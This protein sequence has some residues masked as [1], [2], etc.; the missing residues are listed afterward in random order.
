MSVAGVLELFELRKQFDTVLALDGVS[1]SFSGGQ[2]VALVGP[3]GAGKSTLVKCLAGI[4]KADK[5]SVT[6]D[7]RGYK[8]RGPADAKSRGVLLVQQELDIF[9]ELTVFENWHLLTEDSAL[10]RTVLAERTY[11]RAIDLPAATLE[12]ID[13]QLLLLDAAVAA[14]P[15]VLLLDE[16]TS[17][18]DD[19]SAAEFLQNVRARMT[20]ASVVIVTTH[21]QK[22]LS[23]FDRWLFI[24]DGVISFDTTSFELAQEYYLRGGARSPAPTRRRKTDTAFA[25]NKYVSLANTVFRTTRLPIEPGKIIAITTSTGAPLFELARA[26]TAELRR[27]YRVSY[28]GPERRIDQ[29]FPPMSVR[30]H[31]R[32]YL[33]GST[34]EFES[35]KRLLASLGISC[36]AAFADRTPEMLSGGTQQKLL[37]ALALT[38][39]AAFRVMCEPLR[40]VDFGS[41]QVLQNT[42][43]D[44][45]AADEALFLFSHDAELMLSCADLILIV[46]IG[47]PAREIPASDFQSAAEL[48][49]LI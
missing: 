46:S 21:R 30:D 2:M 6:L 48:R 31:I 3:N 8:P 43:V 25:A 34:S 32:A 26:L 47:S 39:S 22:D 40:G 33:S 27:N 28:L 5:G 1:A 49:R 9:P 15:L 19:Q 4:V 29:L 20:P 45:I 12:P 17:L 23:S 7:G 18:L 37:I 35:F 16:P 38:T 41:A 42:L 10:T 36:D 44:R 24:E 14:Q 11:A 13:A